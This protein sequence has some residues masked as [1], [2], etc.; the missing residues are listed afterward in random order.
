M[1]R[2]KGTPASN[3]G[4]P[5]TLKR[6]IDSARRNT[7]R[8]RTETLAF[9]GLLAAQYPAHLCKTRQ[10]QRDDQYG[11]VVCVHFPGGAKLSWQL[12]GDEERQRFADLPMGEND[13]D[14]MT[15]EERTTHIDTLAF[16]LRKTT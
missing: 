8:A 11:L 2:V 10:P 5:W 16:A 1:G 6:R 13:S 7:K 15:H 9:V 4:E 3:K 14:R 12:S